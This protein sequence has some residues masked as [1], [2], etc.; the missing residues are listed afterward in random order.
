MSGFTQ[1]RRRDHRLQEEDVDCG[2]VVVHISPDRFHP[3]DVLFLL[4]G[5][6]DKAPSIRKQ[7]RE[8]V[9]Q[10]IQQP[11]LH[12]TKGDLCGKH[13][14]ASSHIAVPIECDYSG[15]DSD[16]REEPSTRRKGGEAGKG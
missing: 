1:S 11:V 3:G 14:A 6:H 10:H 2:G 12:S 13:I 8:G 7:Q 4:E 15:V 16:S 5:P 9:H